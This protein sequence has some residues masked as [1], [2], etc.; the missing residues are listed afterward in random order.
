MFTM[1][2][3]K[4]RWEVSLVPGCAETLN[5]GSTITLSITRIMNKMPFG[6]IRSCPSFGWN[7]K[8]ANAGSTRAALM[9][10][11]NNFILS[12]TGS[13]LLSVV[14]QKVQDERW[15]ELQDDQIEQWT[16]KLERYLSHSTSANFQLAEILHYLKPIQIVSM[17]IPNQSEEEYLISL[18]KEHAS[19]RQPLK[20]PQETFGEK[21]AIPACPKCK[22]QETSF[23]AIQKRSADEPTSYFYQCGI[24]S[25]GFFW[26]SR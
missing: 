17:T 5:C 10:K 19:T 20:T 14:R 21:I 22:A 12:M 6:F 18:Y 4:T 3:R 16:A 9:S 13:D 24:S 11:I 25:C 1:A 15:T 23:F 7:D 26:K 2:E 8:I